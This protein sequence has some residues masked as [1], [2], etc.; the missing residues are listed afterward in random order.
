MA[1]WLASLG[2]CCGLAVVGTGGYAQAQKSPPAGGSA[3][4]SELSQTGGDS[5]SDRSRDDRSRDERSHDDDRRGEGRR[6]P[7]PRMGDASWWNAFAWRRV[8]EFVRRNGEPLE[9]LP[10]LLVPQARAEMGLD[11][12]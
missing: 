10:L 2:L 8:A 3:Q 4:R 1:R 9:L 7:P 5:R 6:P 12:A 11:E